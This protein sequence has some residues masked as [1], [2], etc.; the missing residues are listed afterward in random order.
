[1]GY[2]EVDRRL[3]RKLAQ[4]ISTLVVLVMTLTL[5]ACTNKAD[6][7]KTPDPV[8]LT[9]Y[10]PVQVGGPLTIL[11][12]ALVDEFE[13]AHPHITINPIYTGD[14]EA[15]AAKIKKSKD[16]DDQPD[17]FVSLAS[18]RFSMV[19]NDL[20]TPLDGFITEEDPGYISG[21]VS[22]FIRESYVDDQ[23][24]GI[25]FQR[26]T[27]VLYYN[28]EAFREA[29]LDP[30]KPPS[31]WDELA[32]YAQQ[33]V[34]KD[35]A[36][37]VERWGVGIGLNKGTAQWSFGA[38]AVQNHL[39]GGNL[40]SADG[41]EIS[42]DTPQNVEVIKFW[43]ALQK[44]YKAMPEGVTQWKDLLPQFLNGKYAMIYNTSGNLTNIFKQ[45]NFEFG[46][47][48]LPGNKQLGTLT[49]GGNLY[50][51]SNISQAKK[52]AAWA[53]IKFA[54]QTDQVVKWSVDTGYIPTRYAAFQ[55]DLMTKYYDAV[56]QAKISAIQLGHAKPE[57]ATYDLEEIW[58]I[59]Y[60]AIH[61]A[62]D[63]RLSPETALEQAQYKS[64][65]VLGKYK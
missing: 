59:L 29:G 6:E 26:S 4:V 20:V 28:K 31:N 27:Q 14:Y 11:M 45:A 63:D 23:V 46:T 57:I 43:R 35:E 30:E 13:T 36:G 65:S 47:A 8:A 1:M 58:D 48:F 15:T 44:E 9:F 39:T 52:E 10:Y 51:S 12:E 3:M 54:T 7:I 24:W 16:T 41:K 60:T 34:K 19:Q 25:P 37:N 5:A 18:E 38:F 53:F 40:M 56:P 50:I 62:L 49:G 22:E 64:N 2:R 61:L 55:T 32:H 17:F 42:L 33:L 21:F